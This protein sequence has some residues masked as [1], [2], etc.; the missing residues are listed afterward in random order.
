MDSLWSNNRKKN[1]TSQQQIFE[2]ENCLEI[3]RK[4][5]KLQIVKFLKSIEKCN[6]EYKKK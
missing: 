4:N 3:E 2:N 6:F 5:T 1:L